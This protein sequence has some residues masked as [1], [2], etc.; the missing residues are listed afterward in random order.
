M[1]FCSDYFVNDHIQNRLKLKRDE[2]RFRFCK[3]LCRFNLR[4]R[5][6]VGCRNKPTKPSTSQNIFC[7]ICRDLRAIWLTRKR[8]K[9]E[10][11]QGS[12]QRFKI[13]RGGRIKMFFNGG[14]RFR[15]QNR[16]ILTGVRVRNRLCFRSQKRRKWRTFNKPLKRIIIGKFIQRKEEPCR[17]RNNPRI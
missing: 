15:I 10:I 14:N 5:R 4:N 6:L 17:V 9:L 11:L 13:R 16:L 1:I 7:C 8:Q 12:K 3:Q 2:I